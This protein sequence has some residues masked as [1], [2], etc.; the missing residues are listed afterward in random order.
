MHSLKSTLL[1]LVL[2]TI[3]ITSL[4]AQNETEKP[5]KE[6]GVGISKFQMISA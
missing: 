3:Q 2:G 1:V 5:I 4:F 6:I